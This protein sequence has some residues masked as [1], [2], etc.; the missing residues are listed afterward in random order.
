VAHTAVPLLLV[1]HDTRT[2][3]LPAL[4]L[5]DA[6]PIYPDAVRRVRARGREPAHAAR[7]RRRGRGCRARARRRRVAGA[8]AAVRAGAVARARDRKSTR[9]NSRHVKIPYAV[10]C[11]KKKHRIAWWG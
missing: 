11:V 3:R 9:L 8:A 2:P 1:L 4:P 10:F 5:H 6:L 7:D